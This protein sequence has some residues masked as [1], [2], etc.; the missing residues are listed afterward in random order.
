MFALFYILKILKH[1]LEH[2]CGWDILIDSRVSKGPPKRCTHRWPQGIHRLLAES[3]D[4]REQKE[5]VI[6]TKRR[7]I[8]F[9]KLRQMV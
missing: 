8:Q 4:F 6:F 9:L 3:S 2:E 5:S 7:S 1:N